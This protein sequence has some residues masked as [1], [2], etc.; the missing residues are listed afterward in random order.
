MV[1]CSMCGCCGVLCGWGELLLKDLGVRDYGCV[2]GC[3]EGCGAAG[4]SSP[5]HQLI[6]CSMEMQCFLCGGELWSVWWG[7]A[8]TLSRA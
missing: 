7:E 1:R 8:G 3:W 6:A 2:G 5:K 4:G